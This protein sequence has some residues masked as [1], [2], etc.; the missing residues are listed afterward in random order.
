MQLFVD[1]DILLFERTRGLNW[2]GHVNGMD[3][4]RK[5]NYLTIIR[6]EVDYEETKKQMVDCV[7]TDIK[8]G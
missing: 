6:R 4:R 2:I 7:Q 5:V 1:S 8:K 3:I